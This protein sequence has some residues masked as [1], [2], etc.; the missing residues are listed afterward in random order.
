MFSYEK[1]M[2]CWLVLP[3]VSGIDP[4]VGIAVGYPSE[5]VIMLA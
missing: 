1:A 5:E 4:S 2:L 3:S